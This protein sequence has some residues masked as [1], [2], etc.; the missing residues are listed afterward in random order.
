VTDLDKLKSLLDEWKVPYDEE[1][2]VITL[3][4]DAWNNKAKVIGYSGFVTLVAFDE[5]GG[6]SHVGIWE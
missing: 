3:E 1:D 5:N 6:F 2:N 4:A